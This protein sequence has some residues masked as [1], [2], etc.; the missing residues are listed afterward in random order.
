VS[1]LAERLGFP[2]PHRR[3]ILPTRLGVAYAFVVFL[4]FLGA[5]NYSD[6]M[7]LLLAFVLAAL[8]WHAMVRCERSLRGLSVETAAPDIGFVGRPLA[9]GLTLRGLR[10]H[11]PV[12]LAAAFRGGAW[13]AVARPEAGETRA[14]ALA[15]VPAHRGRVEVPPWRLACE[16]PLGLF[17][18]WCGAPSERVAIVAPAPAADAPV[19]PSSGAPDVSGQPGEDF[20]DLR[21]WRQGDSPRRVAW[22]VYARRHEL[23][24]R[25]FEPPPPPHRMLRW[26]ETEAFAS[27]QGAERDE[28]RLSILCRWVLDAEREG[29][30]YGLALP[31]RTVPVG[32]DKTHLR[33]CLEA[34]A[35][36]GV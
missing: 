11:P 24:V 5:V 32:R 27:G 13:T 12:Q 21:P 28:R 16:Q 23:L 6:N 2:R 31:S 14:L 22:R 3:Y 15:F 18:A 7:A 25:T 1:T 26:E 29:A 34:L 17:R 35:L 9:V 4:I 8:A 36:H 33:A 10:P 30:P 19:H 20:R